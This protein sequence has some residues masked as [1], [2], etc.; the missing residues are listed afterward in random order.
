MYTVPKI[1]VIPLIHRADP[2]GWWRARVGS[3]SSN[4]G[5][6]IYFINRITAHPDF[7]PTTLANDIAV[8]RTTLA[9]TLVPGSVE[10][11]RVAGAAFTFT[12]NQ[13]VTAIGW[14]A[15]SVSTLKPNIWLHSFTT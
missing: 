3:T 11:A 5:G 4:A 1:N 15:I 14:G 2:V 9:I 10:V 12:T 8:I 6:T 7:S 13:V